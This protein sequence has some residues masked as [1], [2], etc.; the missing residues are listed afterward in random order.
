MRHL[1]TYTATLSA[2]AEQSFIRL[3][4]RL[5]VRAV[6]MG[7]LSHTQPEQGFRTPD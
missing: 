2:A 5:V 6:N 1:G 3:S 4:D 7:C